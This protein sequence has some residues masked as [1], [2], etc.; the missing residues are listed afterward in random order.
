[1]NA[2]NISEK[3]INKT[4]QQSIN[5]LYCIVLYPIDKIIQKKNKCH[6]GEVI[7]LGSG[8]QLSNFKV[9]NCVQKIFGKQN[10]SNFKII[11]KKYRSYDSDMWVGNIKHALKKYKFKCKYSFEEAL[12]DMKK[13]YK[14]NK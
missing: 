13:N 3:N 10:E 8:K 7:N 1:M 4:H 9:L 14:L 2:K 12:C 11:N 6:S 5:L